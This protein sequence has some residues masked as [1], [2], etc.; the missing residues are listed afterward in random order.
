M[1]EK[2]INPKFNVHEKYKEVNII[3]SYRYSGGDGAVNYYNFDEL[4]G[5]T[6]FDQTGSVD[7]VNTGA[8]VGV[9]GFLNTAYSFDGVND[10][11]RWNTVP[12]FD[13]FPFSFSLYIKKVAAGDIVAP[14]TG[15]I[16]GYTGI[17]IDIRQTAIFLSYHE[18]GPVAV[19]NRKTFSTPNGIGD[20]NWHKVSVDCIDFNTVKIYIDS[21]S[22]PTTFHSGGATFYTPAVDYM[23]MKSLSTFYKGSVDEMKWYDRLMEV[24]E[25]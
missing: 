13:V 4:S 2:R 18:G 15:R 1:A 23:S 19:A 9:S 21:V 16:A 20:T 3:N 17:E 8:T 7:G 24:S 14:L 10:F 22:K 5:T 6:L 12:T 11:I 25:R